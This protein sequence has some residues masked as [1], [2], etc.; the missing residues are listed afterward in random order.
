MKSRED[1]V[2]EMNKQKWNENL[3]AFVSEEIQYNSEDKFRKL[4]ENLLYEEDIEIKDC[5]TLTSFVI[6]EKHS[7]LRSKSIVQ[8]W[9]NL[10]NEKHYKVVIKKREDGTVRYVKFD[11]KKHRFFIDEYNKLQKELELKKY[12]VLYDGDDLNQ[13]IPYYENLI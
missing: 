13:I 2:N 7:S 3:D 5:C 10:N 6:F 11:I 8:H 1:I 12:N 4:D 9:K